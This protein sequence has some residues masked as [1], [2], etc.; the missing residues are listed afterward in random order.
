MEKNFQIIIKD[1]DEGTTITNT[2]TNCIL[3]V[4][5][6][7]DHFGGHTI[8]CCNGETVMKAISAIDSLS[9]NLKKKIAKD[10]LPAGLMDLLEKLSKGE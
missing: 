9:T 10:V 6:E 7:G 2:K 5:N 3:C 8:T 1:L 4:V